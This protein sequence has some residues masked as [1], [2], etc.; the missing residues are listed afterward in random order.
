MRPFIVEEALTHSVIGSFLEA[1]NTL[2]YGFSE[3]VYVKA[4]ERELLEKGHRVQREFAVVVWYKGRELAY[5]R[6]DMVV[7]GRVVIEVKSTESLHKSAIRQLFNYLKAT[8]IEV[9]LLLHFSP[10]GAK[11]Y[12][13]IHT[14]DRK[15]S[16]E[17]VKSVES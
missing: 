8:N 4:L 12:R 17:S 10:N 5:Q 6:L 7:D 9:G 16:V 3:P 13:Q 11:F 2:G 1:Y 15:R 14:R